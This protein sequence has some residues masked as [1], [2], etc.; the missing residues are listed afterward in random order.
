[1]F[2]FLVVYRIRLIGG[3]GELAIVAVHVSPNRL[4]V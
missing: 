3:H 2:E 1:M 4:P